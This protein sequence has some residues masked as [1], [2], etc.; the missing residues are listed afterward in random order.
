ME[1]NIIKKYY[2]DPKFK[3]AFGSYRNIYALIKKNHPQFK[4]N[5]IDSVLKKILNYQ[6][7]KKIPPIKFRRK[8][9]AE[10]ISYLWQADLIDLSNVSKKK[11][12]KTFKYRY[13]LVVIDVFS[14]FAWIEPI[15]SKSGENTTK[16]FISIIK[17][18]IKDSVHDIPL[19]LH[20]DL[21]KEFFNYHFKNEISKLK[22][23]HYF[24]S[25]LHK[26]AV[27][28]RFIRTF[29]N[30][31]TKMYSN[32]KK[33]INS[34]RNYRLFLQTIVNL[35]NSTKSRTHGLA[36]NNVKKKHTNMIWSRLY[37]KYFENTPRLIKFIPGDIVLVA[38]RKS[39]FEK[40]YSASYLKSKYIIHDVILNTYPITYRLRDSEGSISENTFY[41]E[42][43]QKTK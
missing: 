38:K 30:R 20:T 25:G 6:L 12:I 22:I 41:A 11:K 39:I 21:G 4:K 15:R 42:D 24:T 7:H 3:V 29:M 31:F 43:L 8:I 5:V 14:K 19:N 9:L 2:F 36:P 32:D 40:G 10:K 16:A 13:I 33:K 28:E 27:C 26:A 18:A 1:E 34:V 35:Y 23:N 17:R 37:G